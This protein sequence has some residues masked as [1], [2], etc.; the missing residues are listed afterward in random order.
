MIWLQVITL[1]GSIV[2]VIGGLLYLTNRRIDDLRIDTNN[3]IDGINKRIDE[4][5]KRID[6]IRSDVKGILA[7]LTNTRTGTANR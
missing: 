4:V 5:N 3:R 2:G 7:I 6:E 1:T